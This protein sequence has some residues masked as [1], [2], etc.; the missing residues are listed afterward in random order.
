VSIPTLVI[1][2]AEDP[3]I[4]VSGGQT[5][6]AASPGAELVV[7]EGMGHDLPQALYP[8]ITDRIAELVQRAEAKAASDRD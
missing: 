7:I 5:T 8:E 1:H 4:Q 3:L 2:G 6:A